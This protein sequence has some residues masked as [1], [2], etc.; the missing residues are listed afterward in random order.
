[1]ARKKARRDP[2]EI[3]V[4]SFS[5]IAFLLIIFFILAT[6]LV[7]YKGFTTEL[8]AGEKSQA[9]SQQKSNIVNLHDGRINF[10]DQ[11]V[12]VD[13][14]ERRLSLLQLP[15]KE[16][17]Q[18]VIMLEATGRVPYQMYYDVMLAITR[19]GGVIGIVREDEK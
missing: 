15:Q 7:Q 14:L 3:P 6:S 16:G 2:G 13:Q 8:P 11:P 5:D 12:S 4:S 18:K 17:D 9:Q 1:M 10:N 19:S